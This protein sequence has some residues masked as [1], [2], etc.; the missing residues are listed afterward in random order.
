MSGAG[1]TTVKSALEDLGFYCVDNLPMAL[2]P[3]FIE[4]LAGRD[5]VT[6]A[7]LV[8]DARSGDFLTDTS[9][10]LSDLRAAGHS[11]DVLFLDAPSEI[12]LR[13]FSETRRRHPLL[14]KDIR[15]DIEAERTRLSASARGSHRGHRYRRAQRAQLA[16]HRPWPLRPRRGQPGRDA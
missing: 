7:G 2:L 12:I 3:K 13:R 15:S 9:R 5:E 4:L 14:G 1:K 10:V 6:R 11:I 16:R 8:V